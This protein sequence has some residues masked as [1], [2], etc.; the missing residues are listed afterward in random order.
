MHRTSSW[1][2]TSAGGTVGMGLC[3]GVSAFLKSVWAGC[4]ELPSLFWICPVVFVRLGQVP[5]L[6]GMKHWGGGKHELN[7]QS[8]VD[9]SAEWCLPF[10]VPGSTTCSSSATSQSVPGC[11]RSASG[12]TKGTNSTSSYWLRQ[13]SK[14]ATTLRNR[15]YRRRWGDHLCKGD[16]LGQVWNSSVLCPEQDWLRLAGREFSVQSQCQKYPVNG[17]QTA[18][19]CLRDADT[20]RIVFKCCSGKIFSVTNCLSCLLRFA[21]PGRRGSEHSGTLAL[22][23]PRRR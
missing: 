1:Y 21:S 7:R 18:V 6:A 20:L 2:V 17:D 16:A 10:Q 15:R 9:T 8:S 13:P 11:T 3:T 19:C 12:S 14:P 5:P 22:P 23:T 4:P